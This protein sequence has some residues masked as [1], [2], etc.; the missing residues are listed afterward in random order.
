MRF[1]LLVPLSLAFSRVPCP[2]SLPS[3]FLPSSLPSLPLPLCSNSVPSRHFINLKEPT[4]PNR[5]ATVDRLFKQFVAAIEAAYFSADSPVHPIP[6]V[7]EYFDR[8]R[9]AGIKVALNTGYPRQIA[10]HLI[11]RMGFE[12]HIDGSLVSEEVGYGRPYPYMVH[13]LMKQLHIAKVQ[14]VAKVGDTALD[15]EEGRNAG[16]TFVIGVLSGADDAPTLLKHGA[17]AVV[18]TA[19]DYPL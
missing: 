6:G 18:K 1:P 11:K 8:L 2:L 14:A 7:V 15:M 10:D 5:E 9:A 12:G 13:G 19:V 16:C 3:S 4:D 17:S